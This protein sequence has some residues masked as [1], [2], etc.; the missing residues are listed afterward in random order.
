[1]PVGNRALTRALA[2]IGVLT[3]LYD[4]SAWPYLDR[5]LTLVE[6]GNASVLLSFADLYLGRNTD[7]SYNNE[8]DAN[9]AVNCLDRPVPSDVAAYDAL[10][11]AFAK[12]SPFFGPATQYSNLACAYWPVKPT[13]SAG[14]ITADGAPPILLVGGTND[15]ATPYAWAQAVHQSLAGSVLLTRNGNG[16]VSYFASSCAETIEDS[17]LINLKLP[18][19]GYT[20]TS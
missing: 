13:G 4:Q 5:A 18:A 14:P 7:G 20:C 17:Y 9:Y 8:N 1:M 16:H 3:P 15:P 10:G 19:E 12:A 6:Q 11:P 2:V